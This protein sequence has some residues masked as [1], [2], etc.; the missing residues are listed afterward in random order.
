MRREK[1]DTELLKNGYTV[2]LGWN[3][4]IWATAIGMLFVTCLEMFYR[5]IINYHDKYMSDMHFYVITN[6]QEGVEHDRLLGFLFTYFYQINDNIMEANVYM[7][8]VVAA[9]V[10][11][12][13]LFIR[14]LIKE[15]GLLDRVP[16]YA[17]QFFSLAA[18]FIGPA[19]VPVLHEWYYRKSFSA[20]AW[21]SPTQQ[22]MTFLSLIASLCFL[23]MYM[24]Y[25]EKGVHPGWWAATAFMVFMSAF[26]KPS[27]FL[28]MSITVVVLFLIELLSGGIKGF[29]GRF[30]KLVIMGCTMIPA[31]LYVLY[32]QTREFNNAE[33]AL[34]GE[35]HRV[36]FEISHIFEEKPVAGFIFGM[37]FAI[38]VFAANFKRFKDRKYLFVLGIFLAGVLQWAFITET[39]KRGNYGNFSW[40]KVYGTYFI[41]LASTA[42]AL[43][44]VYNKDSVFKGR[45]T[46]RIVYLVILA[47]ALAVSLL[48][49]L[50][51]F[52]LI[53]TGHGY[54]L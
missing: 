50:R 39:G 3:D 15:D 36:I 14:F 42:L 27:F 25:D 40:G 47:A 32:L 6:A 35:E 31:G 22:T 52:L 9:T 54:M 51:Y 28:S 21:H 49:Q 1:T 46:A 10:V 17:M 38:I 16:R 4:L 11:V 48:S 26:T 8:A 53:L 13:F 12:N 18:M 7:A 24:H 5:M 20:Y 29:W 41:N 33:A 34:D 37:T 30:I 23:K 45:K 19:F 43:E 2:T 44:N